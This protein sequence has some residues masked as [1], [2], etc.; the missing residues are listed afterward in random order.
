MHA[1]V[2][3]LPQ[4]SDPFYS[5]LTPTTHAQTD[6]H[7]KGGGSSPDFFQ[8]FTSSSPHCH[9]GRS[10]FDSVTDR[11][12][13]W[14][15]SVKPYK[16]GFRGR[17]CIFYCLQT[18]GASGQ[19]KT[20]CE[21][22]S[23]PVFA[24][25]LLPNT[26][27]SVRPHQAPTPDSSR[28]PLTFG[29]AQGHRPTVLYSHL[30][31]HLASCDAICCQQAISLD[32]T[33]SFREAIAKMPSQ[34]TIRSCHHAQRARPSRNRQPSCNPPC[35]PTHGVLLQKRFALCQLF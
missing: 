23:Q 24:L 7:T 3:L 29:R 15:I 34:K 9:N 20:A 13:K 30:N 14:G 8:L 27:Q 31:F 33:Q 35:R 32:V 19:N 5:Q 17:N 26:R 2:S 25:F 16:T 10:C 1:L 6:P 4:Q 22:I 28:Q 12:T 11:I 18:P 21:K